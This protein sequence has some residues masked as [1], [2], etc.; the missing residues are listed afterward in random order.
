MDFIGAYSPSHIIF[1]LK[2]FSVT[3]LVAFISITLSFIFGIM[4]GVLRYTKV[5]V[6]SHLLAVWVETIRNLP[7]LLI[8]FFTFFALPEIGL[9]LDKMAAAILA[10]V[11]FES[12]MLSEIV[13]GGLN[14]IE[15]G[16]IE[17]A[18]SS[19]LN[20]LQTLWYIILPQALRRMVP[21][22]VS[23]FISLLKDTS[24]AVVISLP[25]LMNHAQIINGK[26]INYVIPI[27][28]LVAL[29]YFTVNYLL[30]LVSRRLENKYI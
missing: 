29:M 12:T 14:S 3:L 23:Q 18:R 5:P 16:Q 13:R 19:G 10:L 30:S 4:I 6:I 20:Y 26:N 21:P 7:L 11:V 22:I 15:K 17:A 8:I 28:I 2:G 1:L 24:F 25:E 27:F 9:K